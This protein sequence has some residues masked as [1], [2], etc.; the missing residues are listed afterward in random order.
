MKVQVNG[1]TLVFPDSMS[2]DEV[3][4]VLRKKFPAP[5]KA[6]DPREA[7]DAP[8][9]RL[10]FTDTVIPGTS[11]VNEALIGVGRFATELGQGAKQKALMV[12]DEFTGEGEADEYTEQIN[13]ET[14]RWDKDT[15][16]FGLEDIGYYGSMLGSA[17]LAPGGG[18]AG[19][20]AVGALENA[21]L[22]QQEAEWSEVAK[23][24]ALGGATAGAVRAAPD[25]IRGARNWNR[26]R[27]MA[28][29]DPDV[30]KVGTDFGVKV[31]PDQL[32]PTTVNKQARDILDTPIWSPGKAGKMDD[33]RRVLEEMAA[34]QKHG[35]VQEQF[36]KGV[37]ALRDAD[38]NRWK[39]TLAEVGDAPVSNANIGMEFKNLM[40][41]LASEGMAV[42]EIKAIQKMW[43][44]RPKR[45]M[46][47][48]D[49]HKFRAK[50]GA[51]AQAK[52]TKKGLDARVPK[53]IYGILSE[54]MKRGIGHTY[55][56]A[57]LKKFARATDATKDMYRRIDS[58]RLGKNLINNK[59]DSESDFIRVAL[60]NNPDRRQAMKYILGE[61]GAEPIRA[62]IA[63]DIFK[64]FD[65]EGPQAAAKR[66]R[67]MGDA[68]DD[69]FSP[70]DAAYYRGMAKFMDGIADNSD[71]GKS[72]TSLA[73]SATVLGGTGAASGPAAIAGYGALMTAMRRQDVTAMLQKLST[74]K[75]GTKIHDQ[76]LQELNRAIGIS[77]QP[78]QESALRVPI[79]DGRPM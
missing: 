51:K 11:K 68:I 28:Q 75:K 50:F 24:A 46:S 6:P 77:A 22:P 52:F 26:S 31:S 21:L 36:N 8:G 57:G 43:K 42:D 27:K 53:R 49:L 56:D 66:I 40:D 74:V 15:E 45:W 1:E 35:S 37:D 44:Q 64:K 70:D 34:K 72:M 5:E 10:P 9:I 13:E 41:E 58:T 3:K 7:L 60:G 54:E 29:V 48:Q 19:T 18:I 16:G 25:A 14:A 63:T 30:A 67:Q 61:K 2:E 79:Q 23:D 33:S 55:G 38:S 65:V 62:E 39:S 17:A 69:F 73:K 20:A 59:V 71:L 4:A 12:K 47:V 78:A 32:R 76:L